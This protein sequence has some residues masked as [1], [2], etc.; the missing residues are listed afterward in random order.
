[1]NKL[2]P[3]LFLTLVLLASCTTTSAKREESLVLQAEAL[4]LL[5]AKE[6]GQAV[7]LLEEAVKLSPKES[8]GRYNLVLA[9]LANEMFDEAILLCDDSYA[10]FPAHLQFMLA[11]AFALRTKGESD[12]AFS[13]YSAIL[14]IDRGNFPLHAT[15]MELALEKG[16]TDFAKD[17][18]LYLLSVHEE[19][20][21]A[22]DALATIEGEDSWYALAASL[23]KEASA[24]SPESIQEQSK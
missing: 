8:E 17:T 20:V 22:F 21:K 14:A 15:L 5:D 18:A 23:M 1:M 19:E 4:S 24:E 10:L 9:L 11:K 16:N 2:V 6:Y 13:L 3:I 12:A 7:P